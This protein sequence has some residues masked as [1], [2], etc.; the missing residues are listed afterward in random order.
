M[1]SEGQ[2][3]CRRRG[4]GV[5]RWSDSSQQTCAGWTGTMTTN[6]SEQVGCLACNASTGTTIRGMRIMGAET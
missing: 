3:V 1:P 6:Y 2:R 5:D 4:N